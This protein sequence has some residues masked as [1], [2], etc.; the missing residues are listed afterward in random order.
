MQ[1]FCNP[2]NYVNYAILCVTGSFRLKLILQM[3][4]SY[5]EANGWL[6]HNI[7][8]RTTQ[9]SMHCVCLYVTVKFAWEDRREFLSYKCDVTQ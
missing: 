6:L 3:R 7:I 9:Q 1:H 5:C 4:S 8:I 2:C